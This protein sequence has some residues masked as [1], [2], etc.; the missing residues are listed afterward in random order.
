MSCQAGFPQ[1][2]GGPTP[3]VSWDVCGD[4]AAGVY[5][6]ACVHEHVVERGAC[7]THRPERGVTGCKACFEQGH[8][9]MMS[10]QLVGR[11]EQ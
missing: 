9:C 3:E 6:Y 8:D 4:R 7:E 10:F 1:D 11:R 5:R 2:F